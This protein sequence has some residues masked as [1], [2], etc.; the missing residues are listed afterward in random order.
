MSHEHRELY[1]QVIIDHG[2]HP[3]N[4]HEMAQP[5]IKRVGHNPLCGDK[6]VLFIQL[7]PEKNKILDISF[8]GEGCAIS[9][10]S[11]SLMT[12]AVKGLKIEDALKL[13]TG[14]HELVTGGS[15][16]LSDEGLEEKLG[17]L[18]VLSG[19]SAYPARVKCAS[20]AWQVLKAGLSEKDKDQI[21]QEVRTE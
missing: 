10:A 15:Q 21:D 4:F 19:V 9:M 14:V 6:L 11:S 17:K 13:F 5:S 3:K 7:D 2:K 16:G 12:E 8:Q 1:Q 20:L 18:A